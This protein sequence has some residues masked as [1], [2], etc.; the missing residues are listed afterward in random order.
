M[1][2]SAILQHLDSLWA[3]F[4]GLAS[5]LA[6]LHDKCQMAHRD[7]KPSNILLYQQTDNSLV[8]KIADFGLAVDL[9]DAVVW[10]LGTAEAKSAWRYD[11]PEVRKLIKDPEAR[12]APNPTQL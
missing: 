2:Q 8:T 3:Q 1:D 7:I 12:E 10:Q 9:E 4:E 5:A 11:A 6:Y